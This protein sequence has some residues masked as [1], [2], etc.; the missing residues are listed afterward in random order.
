[1]HADGALLTGHDRLLGVL[2]SRAAARGLHILQNQRLV[3]IVPEG[4]LAVAVA[5]FDDGAILVF[6]LLEAD[7]SAVFWGLFLFS[8][9]GV[10]H[11]CHRGKEANQCKLFHRWS[12]FIVYN[13][14]SCTFARPWVLP[15]ERL[16]K[17]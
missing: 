12:I 10:G 1:M 7:T 17:Y 5:T 9:L 14:I 15:Q 3:A 16:Q 2:G 11:E 6:S 8:V 13:S 4:K